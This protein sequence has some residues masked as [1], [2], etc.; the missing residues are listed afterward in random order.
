MEVYGLRCVAQSAG[1]TLY[2]SK[3]AAQVACD[4]V[5]N[6]M[7]EDNPD[8]SYEHLFYV[9]CYTLEGDGDDDTGWA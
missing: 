2:K 7:I 1:N 5:N 9:S 4:I 8:F 3:E 6:K